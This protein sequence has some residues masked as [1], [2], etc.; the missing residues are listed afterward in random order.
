MACPCITPTAVCL[1]AVSN[2]DERASLEASLRQGGRDLICLELSQMA[3]FAGNA[4]ELRDAEGNA[5]IAMS[6]SAHAA[7]TITQ[8]EKLQARARI[9]T[10]AVPSIERNAGGSI[11]CML[12]EIFLPR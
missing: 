5:V 2:A 9:V 3:A 11:R 8:L 12:A 4:L 10:V 7:M 6:A 1:D